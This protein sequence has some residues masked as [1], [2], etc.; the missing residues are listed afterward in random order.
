MHFSIFKRMQM[1]T[2]SLS[3]GVEPTVRLADLLGSGSTATV[4]RAQRTTALGPE[5]V[6]VKIPNARTSLN[7]EATA[8]KRFAHPNIVR[9]VESGR[10]CT[11]SAEA[12]IVL[13]LCDSGTVEDLLLARPLTPGEVHMVVSSVGAA[14]SLVHDAGW[15]HG[16]VNPSNVALRST[17]LPCLIDFGMCRPADK[18]PAISGTEGFT[19]PTLPSSP[20][21]D[22]RGLIATALAALGPAGPHPIH[23]RLEELLIRCDRGQ[24]VSIETV[25]QAFEDVPVEHIDGSQLPGSRHVGRASGGPTPP[26][27]R[28]FG[29]R[30]GGDP[31]PAST[32]T[33][34][35]APLPRVAAL[36][37]AAL[38]IAFVALDVLGPSSAAD[39]LSPEPAIA[40]QPSALLTGETE[41]L[42]AEETLATQ[43]VSWIADGSNMRIDHESLDRS[44]LAGS[45]GDVAA[46][47]DWNCDGVQTLGIF[48]PGTGAW[49][50]FDSWDQAAVST[51]E[52]ISE[53][54]AVGA[55]AAVAVERD[56]AGCARP[57]IG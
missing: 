40:T 56:S 18:T 52:V 5:M 36:A 19:S 34:S 23:H 28:R 26:R 15:I 49:F 45:H 54:V 13:E 25:L 21:L 7:A 29:P 31:T 51:V 12:S 55:V 47:G 43:G 41:M 57:V 10:S 14:L 11:P 2:K 44:F 53:P 48:R 37:G 3:P 35:R 50:E 32:S 39:A 24:E 27:T 4:F 8:L 38:L 30:P 17:D 33:T 20:M 42:S 9:L 1:H 22:V 6:A 46:I 16:D